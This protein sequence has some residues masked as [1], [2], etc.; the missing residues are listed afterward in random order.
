MDREE[1]VHR[2]EISGE[3]DRATVEAL[4]LEIRRLA[5]GYGFDIEELRIEEVENQPD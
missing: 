3:M 4:Q 2:F 5:K 1:D